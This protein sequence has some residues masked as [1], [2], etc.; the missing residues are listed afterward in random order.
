M[1][2]ETLDIDNLLG[3]SGIGSSAGIGAAVH[4]G[5]EVDLTANALFS[6]YPDRSSWGRWSGS[7][8]N[9][10]LIGK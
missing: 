10:G 6:Q 5:P 8:N 7:A 2:G 4:L 1:G 9:R 3:S